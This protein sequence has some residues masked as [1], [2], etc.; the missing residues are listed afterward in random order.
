MERAL[1]TGAAGFIGSHLAAELLRRGWAVT[2]LD[3][4]SPASDPVAAEN[5]AE[6]TGDPRFQFVAGDVTG[7]DL[8]MVCEGVRAVFHLAGLPG[9][10]RSWGDRFGDYLACNVLGTQ[11]LL[12]ACAATDVPRLVFASS[13]SVYGPGTGKPSQEGDLPLPLSPYGVSKLAAERLCLAYA[14]QRGAAT[15]VVALR[16]FTVY[17]PRQRP[18]MA[19]SRTMRAALAGRAMSLYGTGAQRR[20][21][22]YVSDAVAATIAAATVEARAEVVNVASGRSVPLSEA[23]KVIARLAGA[24]VPAQRRVAQ[25]GDVDATAADL[26]KA[27]DLLGYQP[28]VELEEGLRRQWEWLAVREDP[29]AVTM[30]TAEAAR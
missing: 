7:G 18:D 13:S 27:E 19:F 2:G 11:R 9:V 1:I 17:G 3:A 29:A 5:L 14:N 16:Y 10:R 21:F 30:A 4:R 22:T 26:G 23:R 8:A 25:P 24:E 15:S 28:A 20:D 12:E 6:L